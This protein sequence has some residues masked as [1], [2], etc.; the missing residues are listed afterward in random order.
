MSK[1]SLFF[2]CSCCNSVVRMEKE[3]TEDLP[4]WAYYDG[5]EWS[6]FQEDVPDFSEK[7]WTRSETVPVE[8]EIRTLHV[9]KPFDE[10]T[11]NEFWAMFTPA[12]I[13][14]NGWTE[15]D[16]EDINKCAVVRCR[17]NKILK[18][19]EYEGWVKVLVQKVV[20]CNDLYRC[21]EPTVSNNGIDEFEFCGISKNDMDEDR[22]NDRWLIRFWTGQGDI[23]ED[24][25]IYTDEKGI[26]HLVMQDYYD[27]DHSFLYIGNAVDKITDI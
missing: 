8:G 9:Y 22:I 19:N 6:D 24:K 11:G 15:A 17:L 7:H 12:L 1:D 3:G 23:G 2:K 14:F 13:H 20:L 27:F 16:E 18:Y 10:S 26:K 25:W 21:F 5:I 4:V